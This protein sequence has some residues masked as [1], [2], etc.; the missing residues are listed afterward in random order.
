MYSY[1]LVS[2]FGI[3]SPGIVLV[4][5][6]V[7]Q[8]SQIVVILVTS[9][10]PDTCSQLNIR[11][12]LC[13]ANTIVSSSPSFFVSVRQISTKSAVSLSSFVSLCPLRLMVNGISTLIASPERVASSFSVIL[14]CLSTLAFLY[15]SMVFVTASLKSEYEAV[16][17]SVLT[18]AAFSPA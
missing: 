13:S 16:P 2:E 4:V 3:V 17:S 6:F 9:H 7:P 8:L 11:F 5:S 10:L 12:A 14:A 15:S 18:T 1:F